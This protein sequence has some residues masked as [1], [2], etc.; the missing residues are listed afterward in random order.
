M[1]PAPDP[2]SLPPWQRKLVLALLAALFLFNGT[3]LN[4]MGLGT[5]DGQNV[6]LV[7]WP[8]VW[9]GGHSAVFI[10]LAAWAGLRSQP[11]PVRLPPALA[12]AALLGLAD[13]WIDSRYITMNSMSPLRSFFVPILLFLASFL[14]MTL[15][16]WPF[17]WQVA[18]ASDR[19]TASWAAA[20]HFSVRQL[21]GWT[22]GVAIFFGLAAWI[23]RE[24]PTDSMPK[25]T[26][27]SAAIVM[28]LAFAGIFSALCLP[29][30]VP[31]IGL[32]LGD[33]NRM[34]F[35][36][37]T[38]AMACLVAIAAFAIFAMPTS[39]SRQEVRIATAST[40]SIL[41]GFFSVTWGS[42]MVAR[43]CGYRLT[44]GR[45]PSEL[46][47]R[48]TGMDDASD[49]PTAVVDRGSKWRFRVLV[50]LLA[51]LSLVLC[52]PA[53]R[54]QDARPEAAALRRVYLE[55]NQLGVN[56]AVLARHRLQV[57]LPPGKPLDEALLKKLNDPS[58]ASS[59][60]GLYL[61]GSR[62]A[63]SQLGRL[64]TLQSLETLHLDQTAITDAALSQVASL[65]KLKTLSLRNTQITDLGLAELRAMPNLTS[66]TLDAT[67][68]TD[69]GLAH[70][71]AI[72][73]LAT[74]TLHGTQVTAEGVAEFRLDAPKCQVAWSPSAQT[75]LDT[76]GQANKSN[77]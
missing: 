35:A 22:A 3:A 72:K 62:V 42:L 74:V 38:V 20:T 70:L 48:A 18:L 25:A 32:V 24:L 65:K 55:W 1:A 27:L 15:I 60:Q 31:S 73:S 5:F 49:S 68:V 64:R 71:A 4:A 19:N 33:G 16:R 10:L 37:W 2:A 28:A 23:L 58:S 13:A 6:P 41:L 61:S 50:G 29:L 43:V 21:L 46:S 36:A 40:V 7:I 66:I 69:A 75:G 77:R 51:L 34:R 76:P 11:I 45:E 59:V 67:R 39:F 26:D 30:A 17:S 52:W 53:M 44:R 14:A 12:V 54:I 9:F 56:V 47:T 8:F 57:T 63:D